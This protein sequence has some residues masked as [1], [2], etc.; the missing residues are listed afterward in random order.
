VTFGPL[1]TLGMHI[2]LNY[3]STLVLGR[4]GSVLIFQFLLDWVFNLKYLVSFYL[5]L[6]FT[7]HH[8]ARVS[9]S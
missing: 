9:V 1:V 7:H 4:A 2:G 8:N 6:I 5:V 3:N